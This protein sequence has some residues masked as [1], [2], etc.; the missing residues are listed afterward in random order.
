MV[1]F[2]GGPSLSVTYARE[3]V[4]ALYTHVAFLTQK[5]VFV[6]LDAGCGRN[7][8]SFPRLFIH[9]PKAREYDRIHGP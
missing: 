8:L 6:H 1:E 3:F 4:C 5:I 2:L 9:S 7:L